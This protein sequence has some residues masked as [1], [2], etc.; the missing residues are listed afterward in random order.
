VSAEY[1]R[2]ELA[3]ALDP[4]HASHILPPPAPQSTRVL[5]VG[6]GAGQTLIASYPDRTTYGIDTDRD[7]LVLG[8]TLT[9]RV[10]FVQAA[11]E[12]MPWCDASFD[13]VVARVALPYSMLADALSEAH[14]VLA[15]GGQVWMTLHPFS[16]VWRQARR[17]GWK[18]WA[19][20]AYVLVN[21]AAFELGL[22]QFRLRRR[23]ESFQTGRGI[24]RALRRAG[25]GGVVVRQGHHFEVRATKSF[26]GQA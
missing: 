19:H 25:F 23:C 17:S 8:S 15:D 21:S 14:R 20:F 1:H 4:S 6:C 10:R 22:P 26:G 18:G 24:R 13:L 16:I 11:A 9:D 2:G 3:V 12:A 5:D 7:A